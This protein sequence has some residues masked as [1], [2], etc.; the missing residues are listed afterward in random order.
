MSFS[1]ADGSRS[2]YTRNGEEQKEFNPATHESVIWDVEWVSD[3]AYYLKYNSGLEDTPKQTQELLKKHKFLYQILNVTDD[4]YI[5]QSTLDKASNQVV[6]KDTLWI[7]QRSDAKKKG[8][9]NPRID[10]LL[11]IRKRRMTRSSANLPSY[12]SSDRGSSP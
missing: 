6:L 9:I 10:S 7:K 4:Y 8:T 1:R 12:M 3:C 2:T 11:A 5:F